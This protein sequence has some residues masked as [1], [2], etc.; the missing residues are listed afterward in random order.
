MDLKSF[1]E[2]KLKIKTQAEFAERIGVDQSSI[3][4]WEK[5]PN[6]I[7]YTIIQTIMEK[8]GA[9]F[10]EVTGWKKPIPNPLEVKDTW[11]KADFTK[12][13]LVEYISDALS[14]MNLSEEYRSE[15][16]DDLTSV[17]SSSIVKPKIAIV[18]R[19]DTGKST[20]IN[21]LLGAKKMPTS[22]TPTTSI[23]VFIKHISERPSFIEEDAWVFANQVG[24]ETMWDETK[25]NDEDYC[26]KW[27]I[28][29]GNA[30]T[31]RSFGSRQGENYNKEAG[32]AVLFV[33]APILKNCEI[34]DLPGFG[35]ETES[36]DNITFST[37]KTADIIIYLSH[38]QAFMRVED[39]T[40]LKR[41]ILELPAWEKKDDNDL[42]P[43][44]NLFIV[45]SQAHGVNNG[46][47][48]I[49]DNILNTGCDNL[50][51]TFPENYWDNRAE[52]TGYTYDENGRSILR[53]RFFTYTTD[54]QDLC[55]SFNS[56]LTELLEKLPSIIDKQT[57][58]L[59]KDY[60]STRSP[61]LIA[62]LEK[63]ETMSN[64]RDRYVSLLKEI[65]D[66]E[67][68]RIAE[69]DQHKKEIRQE[70]FSLSSDSIK[71]FSS[72]CSSVINVD[73]LVQMMNDRGTK[74]KREDIEL[75]GSFL[76]STLQNQCEKILKEK[77]DILS[78][79][80][81][82]YIDSFTAGISSSFE[83][84]GFKVDFDAGWAFASAL[85]KIGMIGGL[86]GFLVSTI[87]GVL[88][89]SSVGFGVGSSIA[90]G[91]STASIFG[92]L[93]IAVGLLIA[94]G[95]GIVKLFGGGWQKSV[96]KKIVATFDENKFN[97]KFRSGIIEYWEQTESAF[98][99]AAAE[100]DTQW[101][102]YV[103]DMRNTVNTYDLQDI[104]SRI[105]NLK[106]LSD[107]F[108]NIPL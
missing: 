68:S 48:E 41:N 43:L 49:L 70:I 54:I 15:Y 101:N 76:Q 102:N 73:S 4:R 107:F 11:E 91:L 108:K 99:Q 106:S 19:S 95:L 39:I 38:S 44:A 45:A 92:P 9:S 58:K 89:F 26:R 94:G 7:P 59:V 23:A 90:L 77:S 53:S 80:T 40:Y 47:P 25:L 13:T 34:I 97:D 93:G 82:D 72:F 51:K 3:S 87:S 88:L 64:D 10:E 56:S 24:N 98:N 55:T 17:I 21:A 27:K 86:G 46:N 18:G 84:N 60:I 67:L 78:E 69:N 37:S 57:K 79:K 63:Y 103:E 6:S 36:D 52:Q 1:R 31:I 20:M 32:A 71:E 50:L 29:A 30:D 96:A 105:A 14:K 75:F 42:K 61:S 85:S 5:D 28:G 81:K 2:D 65:D 74:N 8:T 12:H 66:K 16:V 62:E 35:T 104:Q 83:N 100:L 22:W 33:D